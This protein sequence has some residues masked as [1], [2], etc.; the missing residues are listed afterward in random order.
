[1]SYN[2]Q[3][4]EE[5]EKLEYTKEIFKTDYQFTILY[6]VSKND[7]TKK[8]RQLD[9]KIWFLASKLKN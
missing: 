7:E 9:E 1:M 2:L 3:L 5:E 6:C 4:T 8:I